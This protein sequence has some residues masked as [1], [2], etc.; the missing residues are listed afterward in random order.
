MTAYRNIFLKTAIIILD[1]KKYLPVLLVLSIGSFDILICFVFRA[2]SLGFIE[3]NYAYRR[4]PLNRNLNLQVSR[5]LMGI[6]L[7]HQAQR[8]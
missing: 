7:F 8:S 6:V 4:P 3:G 1:K 2:L 5:R